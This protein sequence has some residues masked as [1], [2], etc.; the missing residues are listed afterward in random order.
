MNK[1]PTNL[2]IPQKPESLESRQTDCTPKKSVA[3]CER[4]ING[5]QCIEGFCCPYMKLCIPSSTT[6]CWGPID[7]FADCTPRCYDNMDQNSCSCSN[8]D[9][10]EKWPKPTCPGKFGM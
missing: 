7:K 3:Q 2:Q 5:D 10:P 8:S 4:C 6:R 1:G 9:F